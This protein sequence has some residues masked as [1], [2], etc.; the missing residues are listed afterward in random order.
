MDLFEEKKALDDSKSKTID[1]QKNLIV[2][3]ISK[4]GSSSIPVLREKTR[5]L[6]TVH[7]RIDSTTSLYPM[8]NPISEYLGSW[9][10]AYT[11]DKPSLRLLHWGD[12]TPAVIRKNLVAKLNADTSSEIQKAYNKTNKGL[13]D[14][15]PKEFKDEQ[16][17]NI[18][19]GE[20]IAHGFH[21]TGDYNFFKNHVDSLSFAGIVLTGSVL[22]TIGNLK[23]LL[24]YINP[25]I[26]NITI[27]NDPLLIM[28]DGFEVVVDNRKNIVRLPFTSNTGLTPINNLTQG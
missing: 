25:I 19:T 8:M 5:Q 24:N 26:E 12:G 16:S 28:E 1:T 11:L 2:S 10:L 3:I 6:R 4:V 23:N 18:L 14:N 17:Q 9:L 13:Y 22:I 20:S 21:I 7:P 15:L 27:N